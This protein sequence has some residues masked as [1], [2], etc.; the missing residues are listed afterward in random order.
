MR[1][2]ILTQ[3]L[4]ANYG[5]ILQAYAL[6]KV[7]RD[8]GHDVTTLRF[9]P[10]VSWVPTGYK[11]HLLT[12]RRFVSKYL[13]G[14]KSIVYCNPDKQTRY[15]YQEL[16]RFID[17]RMNCLEVSA[18]LSTKNLPEFDAYV[19][20]SDQVWRPA[21]SPFLPNFY[22]DFLGDIPAKRIAYAASFGVDIWEADKEMTTRIRPLAQRFDAVS[23]REESGI[24]LCARHLGIQ[25]DLMPDPTLLLTAEDYLE[26]CHTKHIEQEPYIA[27][28]ILDKG[29]KEQSLI[30][31]ISADLGLPV[32]FIGLLDWA[33]STDSLES[34][35]ENIAQAAFVIT[36]SFH[37][38]VF[39]ILFE[40]KFLSISNSRRGSSRFT[41]LLESVGLQEQ[42]VSDNSLE[43]YHPSYHVPDFTMAKAALRNMREQGLSFLKT[44]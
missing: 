26:L 42:L 30:N 16:D 37:G 21:Y 43:R 34:W 28:Y 36:N 39:S 10:D 23:V 44:I 25:A 3:P 8:M 33:K 27:A 13:K 40:R 5:G 38:T 2:C 4:G 14:N 17:T 41:S 11:K 35:I 18:P 19:V 9:R 6:Q 15:A 29:E 12:L 24:D 22:L 20:G 31:R 7:L 1:I 32:R